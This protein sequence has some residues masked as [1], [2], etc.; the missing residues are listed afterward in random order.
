[1][2]A[3]PKVIQEASTAKK[4]FQPKYPG[5]QS[6]THNHCTTLHHTSSS[7]LLWADLARA[8]NSKDYIG[9]LLFKYVFFEATWPFQHSRFQLLPD[10]L[11]EKFCCTFWLADLECSCPKQEILLITMARHED[12]ILAVCQQ[13]FTDKRAEETSDSVWF[14]KLVISAFSH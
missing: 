10:V 13:H 2:C 8:L 14:W 11:I 5:C 7:M 6:D 1:M 4:G 12:K 3:W 9:A